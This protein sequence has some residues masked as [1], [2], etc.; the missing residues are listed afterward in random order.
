MG[1]RKEIVVKKRFLVTRD[2]ILT[3][4]EATIGKGNSYRLSKA[5]VEAIQ[6]MSVKKIFF[7]LERRPHEEKYDFKAV[8]DYDKAE[9]H[10]LHPIDDS[11]VLYIMRTEDDAEVKKD[12][13]KFLFRNLLESREVY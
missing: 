4:N 6:N 10:T 13:I 3:V 11:G 7:V 12:W 5:A 1:R 9:L 8:F 2:C